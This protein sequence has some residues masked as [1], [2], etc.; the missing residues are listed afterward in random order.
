MKI[1]DN[2][3]E[4]LIE[5]DIIDEININIFLSKDPLKVI[6]IINEQINKKNPFVKIYLLI[7]LN[8]NNLSKE[9]LAKINESVL[10]YF[11]NFS[12][13]IDLL[14]DYLLFIFANRLEGVLKREDLINYIELIFAE[15]ENY[16]KLYNFMVSFVEKN[17]SN[18]VF[19]KLCDLFLE[20][21]SKIRTG[22]YYL[23]KL[24]NFLEINSKL[25]ELETLLSKSIKYY[26][27][28]WIIDKY[29]ILLNKKDKIEKVIELLVNLLIQRDFNVIWA[30]ALGVIDKAIAKADNL[31]KIIS[32]II[33]ILPSVK[34]LIEDKKN[35][36]LILRIYSNIFQNLGNIE[37]DKKVDVIKNYV[38]VLEL[39]KSKNLIN[40][41]ELANNIVSNLNKITDFEFFE[42]SN[43]LIK[44]SLVFLDTDEQRIL[45]NNCILN[46]KSDELIYSILINNYEIIDLSIIKDKSLNILEKLLNQ[47]DLEKFKHL[48]YYFLTNLYKDIVLNKDLLVLV[49][50]FLIFY[51][52]FENIKKLTKELIILNKYSLSDLQDLEVLFFVNLIL[53][54]YIFVFYNI[55]N[56]VI[57]Y[58][59]KIKFIFEFLNQKVK[60]NPDL[61]NLYNIMITLILTNLRDKEL[62]VKCD[63]DFYEYIKK[64]PLI[65]GNE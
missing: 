46:L 9:V 62:E 33:E 29:T 63:F 6:E 42:L 20:R 18:I 5:K 56:F 22:I 35:L 58:P 55:T 3:V 50:K 37:Y 43:S 23:K 52:D 13:D 38:V 49:I 14:Y 25:D 12:K 7:L 26:R 2:N 27:I 28:V 51:N 10:N 24:V 47:D 31:S 39:A 30:E 15:E 36:S 40:I 45:L 34:V 4:N 44:E 1:M 16:D 8:Q 19:E 17:L 64:I 48:V 54:N 65:N 32:K 21:F 61:I 53:G 57:K 41:Y 59:E 11:S 60:D